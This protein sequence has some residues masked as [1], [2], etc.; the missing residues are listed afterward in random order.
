VGYKY[1]RSDLIDAAVKVAM[2]EGLSQLSFGKLAKYLEI[3]DRMVVY[4]FPTKDDL[5]S[6]VLLALSEKMQMLLGSAF[7]DKKLSAEALGKKAWPVLTTRSADR[8]FAI[9][10][11]AAGLA[12]AKL[13]PYK[14]VAGSFISDWVE[15]ITPR[16]DG[17]TAEVRKKRALAFVAQLDGLLLIRQLAG[18]AT[19]NAAA[20]QLGFK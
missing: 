8:T 9:F 14:S 18:L 12:A 16:I 6:E 20:A 13:E 10:F 1:E 4:Y 5:I 17:S 3:S 19:A 11:E 15:W 7:G 2:D